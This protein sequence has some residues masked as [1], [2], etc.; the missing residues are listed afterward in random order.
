MTDVNQD[1]RGFPEPR[2]VS[3]IRDADARGCSLL[4]S[5]TS[6]S[7]EA[8]NAVLRKKQVVC[9]RFVDCAEKRT[10]AQRRRQGP[11]REHGDTHLPRQA[12]SGKKADAGRSGRGSARDRDHV[13]V[14]QYRASFVPAL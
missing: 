10:V 14:L 11:C 1:F 12:V 13:L 8:A 4:W 5:I 7:R 3:L 9:R 2:P 6:S